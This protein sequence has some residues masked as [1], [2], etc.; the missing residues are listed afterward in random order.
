MMIK[1]EDMYLALKNRGVELFA[2]VPDSLLKNFCAYVDDNCNSSE[3]I[4]TANEGNA[5]NVIRTTFN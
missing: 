4:I 3:H 5:I 2:G 1:P